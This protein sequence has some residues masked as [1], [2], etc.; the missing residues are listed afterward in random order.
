M[1]EQLKLENQLCFPLYAAARKVTGYYTPYLKPLG[2]T[3]TQYLVFLVL[4]EKG[5]QTVSDLSLAL[6]LDSGTLTPML[7]KLESEGFI[8]RIRSARDERI[9]NISLTRK[10]RLLEEKAKEIPHCVASCMPFTKEEAATLYGYL[11]RIL[12]GA[13][14]QKQ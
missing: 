1:N 8:K 7:K 2:I 5:D 11:Y 9:V 12:G 10:G 3:Y 13:C 4:W 6:F 14:D